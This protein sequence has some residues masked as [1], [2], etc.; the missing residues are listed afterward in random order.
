MCI[1]RQNITYNSSQVKR[2]GSILHKVVKKRNTVFLFIVSYDCFSIDYTII[3]AETIIEC[4]N[5]TTE[6]FDK[7]LLIQ[8]NSLRYILS[9]CRQIRICMKMKH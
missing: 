8:L 5:V 1:L 7:I 9:D 6:I 3:A 2:I 4:Y